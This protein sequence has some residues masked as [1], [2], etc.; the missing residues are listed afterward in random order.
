MAQ[1]VNIHEEA[2]RERKALALVDQLDALGVD[3]E[4]AE[5]LDADGWAAVA[6]L[7]GVKPPSLSTVDWA[8]HL[9]RRREEARQRMAAIADPFEGLPA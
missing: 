8:V 2:A 4:E 3:S 5:W 1:A 7:A 6:R 9:L